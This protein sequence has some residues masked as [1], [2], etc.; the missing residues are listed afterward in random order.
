MWGWVAGAVVL[1][2]VLVFVF[3]RGS[4]DNSTA[5]LPTPPAAIT[6]AAPPTSSPPAQAR[7]S[8]PTPS[9]TGQSTPAPNSEP[10]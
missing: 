9:T 3:T 2:L 8:R 5:S 4:G 1:A 6:G 10:K 7:D